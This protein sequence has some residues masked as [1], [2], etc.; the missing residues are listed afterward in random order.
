MILF[1][2]SY[3]YFCFCLVEVPVET[4]NVSVGRAQKSYHL[5]SCLLWKC[6]ATQTQKYICYAPFV[7]KGY[8][9]LN[10]TEYVNIKYVFNIV[11]PMHGKVVVCYVANWA[12]YRPDAGKFE[13][14]DLE[15]SLCTHLIYSFA[16]LD[17]HSNSIKS[18]G[19]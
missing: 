16:G 18:L 6:T 14:S 12:V 10:D 4:M 3:F 15:P 17:E 1:I 2:P 13:Q 7:V 5:S 8:H 19:K 9:C 11:G